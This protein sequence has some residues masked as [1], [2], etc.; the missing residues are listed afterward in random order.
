MIGANEPDDTTT[1]GAAYSDAVLDHL[2]SGT[3]PK[4]AL[5]SNSLLDEPKKAQAERVPNAEMADSGRRRF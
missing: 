5:D 4:T 1:Q 2:L 3:A